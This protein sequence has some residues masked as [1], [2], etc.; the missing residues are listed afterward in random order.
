MTT[1]RFTTI[2]DL[3]GTEG[4]FDSGINDAG[5]IVGFFY[6]SSGKEHGFLYSG[7]S[8]TTHNDPSGTD[9]TNATGIFS[10][11]TGGASA[12]VSRRTALGYS[13]L[14]LAFRMTSAHRAIS[15]C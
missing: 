7:G 14:I 13:T 11:Q 15:L 1:Y 6:D 2:D 9:S 3:L 8:F 4:T 12:S 10:V 5:Q